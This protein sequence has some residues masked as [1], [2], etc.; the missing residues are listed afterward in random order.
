VS[1][2]LSEEQTRKKYVAAMGAP[3]GN[4]FN[5]FFNECALLH[6]KWTEYESLFGN[7]QSRVDLLNSIRAR[8]LL[9]CRAHLP[10]RCPPSHLPPDGRCGGRSPEEGDS[11]IATSGELDRSAF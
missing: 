9:R 4:M 2:H 10:G 8:L 3:L 7:G 6:V 11:F 5:R 1:E